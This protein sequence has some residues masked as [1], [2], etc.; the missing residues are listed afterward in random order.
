MN[1]NNNNNPNIIQNGPGRGRR[2]ST[3]QQSSNTAGSR[4]RQGQSGSQGVTPL[5][6]GIGNYEG[7]EDQGITPLDMVSSDAGIDLEEQVE[8]GVYYKGKKTLIQSTQIGFPT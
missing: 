6:F 7:Y 4:G 2:R 5:Y 3:G 8:V 1:R